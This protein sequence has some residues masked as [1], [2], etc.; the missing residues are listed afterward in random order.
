MEG[1][2]GRMGSSGGGREEGWLLE[3]GLVDELNQASDFIWAPKIVE[4]PTAS[5][6]SSLDNSSSRKRGRVESC[7]A[8]GTKAGRE[9]MRRDRLN[10]RFTELCSILDPGRPPKA[11]KIAILS[12]ATH[13]LNQ[14]HLEAEKLK[15]SNETLQD[16]IKSLKAE[17]LELRDE[18]VRL[19]AEKERM[20]QMLR[21]FSLAS[22]F[23]PHPA[24]AAATFH[25]ASFAACSKT[26]PYTNY[27][28]TCMWQWMPPAALDT[29]QDLALRPPVA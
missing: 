14:L 27:L 2:G 13:L 11:D 9:K 8:A 24:A 7:S 16:A 10:D 20:E 17:K 3:F 19:K 15:E 4:K 18:K 6:D 25:A 23:V 1:I 12:D 5:R 28:P 26:I 22:P 29:S 21:G